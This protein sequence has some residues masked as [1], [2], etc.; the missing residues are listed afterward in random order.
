MQ[1]L[2]NDMDELFRRAAEN[3]P[4]QPGKDDWQSIAE[5][6]AAEDDPNTVIKVKTNMYGKVTTIFLFLLAVT[7]GW[8][9][10]RKITPNAPAVNVKLVKP[11]K[12]NAVGQPG[13]QNETVI[14][15]K[16]NQPDNAAGNKINGNKKEV[17]QNS[18]LLSIKLMPAKVG[19][20]GEEDVNR[21]TGKFHEV[22]TSQEEEPDLSRTFIDIGKREFLDDHRISIQPFGASNLIV[23]TEGEG[24]KKTN[25][26]PKIVSPANQKK[27]TTTSPKNNSIYIG[28]VAGP[29]VSKVQSMGFSA[30][31][32]Y[33]GLVAGFGISNRLF[34]ETGIIWTKKYYDSK[35]SDFNMDK[36]GPDMVPGMVISDLSSQSTLIEIPVKIRYDLL[37]RRN[38]S[39]F[40]TTGVSAYMLTK[41]K[42]L[43]NVTM[44]GNR[45]KMT[46]LYNQNNYGVPAVANIGIGYQYDISRL[47]Q[48]RI[49]PCLK[50]PLKGMGVGSLPVTSAGLQ[51]GVI[52]RLK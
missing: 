52:R 41:E 14:T 32:I 10:F 34:L 27:N 43:Y 13:R 26:H 21:L 40:I 51:L 8:F 37:R 17:L 29:D 6:I 47:V 11:V 35:G 39:F 31:G 38:S 22:K 1:H 7:I 15:I 18:H 25:E 5:R 2:E 42:N 12:I 45:E 36:I 28:L 24:P 16:E 49:E 30:T 4:L 9:L 44:N 23:E 48:L 3:Y 19:E 46:G 33:T 20:Y 50:V